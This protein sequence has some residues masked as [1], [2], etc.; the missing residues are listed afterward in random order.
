MALPKIESPT[1]LLDLPSNKKIKI[2]YRPFTVKEEKI[3]LMALQGEESEEIVEAIKQTI[4]NCLIGDNDLR[5]F[6]VY[7]MEYIFL[8]IR[9]KSVSNTIELKITDPDDDNQY[10]VTVDID[11]VKVEFSK[12]HDNVIK[13]NED[14][15]L[16]MR[17]PPYNVADKINADNIMTDIVAQC[18]DK[19]LVGD[20]Q[21]IDIKDHTKEEQDEFIDSFSSKT[22]KDLEKYFA[23][24]PK[25][26]HTIKYKDSSGKQK[27][28]DIEGLASFF[29]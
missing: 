23:T 8:N 15:T 27:S 10:D 4:S 16:I 20:D 22:L 7:D 19:I 17:D 28:L 25:L 29:T 18:I 13:I 26:K 6:T 12:D 2:K 24:V 21:V 11:K 14:I 9:S 1:F 5:N 3:L